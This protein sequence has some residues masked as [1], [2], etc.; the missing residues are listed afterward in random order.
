MVALIV[1]EWGRRRGLLAVLKVYAPILAMLFLV[2]WGTTAVLAAL[3]LDQKREVIVQVHGQGINDC[4]HLEV[5]LSERVGSDA[6]LQVSSAEGHSLAED[7]RLTC[8]VQWAEAGWLS[9]GWQSGVIHSEVYLDALAD[10]AIIRGGRFIGGGWHPEY[11]HLAWVAV[12]LLFFLLWRRHERT[13]LERKGSWSRVLGLPLLV[14]MGWFFLV[15]PLISL[16]TLP[17]QTESDAPW[18]TAANFVQGG[19]GNPFWVLY[20][21]FGAPLAEEILFRRIAYKG[22]L[23]AS[24]PILGAM[25]VSAGFV[26]IHIQY[27]S[28]HLVEG[29]FIYTSIFLLSLLH[30]YLFA[31]THHLAAPLLLHVLHN[32]SVLFFV[33]LSVGG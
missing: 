6:R 2:Y 29:L 7:S 11:G 17:F 12:V 15:M 33:G 1:E 22:F 5:H 25:I 8:V 4:D 31:R 10:V 14:F 24:Y 3:V 19:L 20:F 23:E 13:Q 32:G 28:A 26:A 18:N 16:L 21:V 27:L 30:C 9:R